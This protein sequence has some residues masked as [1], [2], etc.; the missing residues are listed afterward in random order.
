MDE[1]ARE[2]GCVVVLLLLLL[3]GVFISFGNGKDLRGACE[4]R[5]ERLVVV[6]GREGIGMFVKDGVVLVKR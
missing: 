6:V 2:L 4:R 3:F 1:K 5:R